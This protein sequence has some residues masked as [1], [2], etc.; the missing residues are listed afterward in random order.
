MKKAA[1]AAECGQFPALTNVFDTLRV[2]LPRIDDVKQSGR[3][4]CQDRQD[5]IEVV[6][7]CHY[8]ADAPR[9]LGWLGFWRTFLANESPPLLECGR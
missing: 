8:R 9:H 2:Y 7:L 1:K 5:M 4:G 3:A 6:R